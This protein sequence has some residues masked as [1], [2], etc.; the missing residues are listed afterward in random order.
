VLEELT[1][2]ERRVVELVVRGWTNQE[3]ADELC[4]TAKTIEWT[5]TKVYRK[6]RVR[7]RTELALKVGGFEPT[8][9]KV[10]L[11]L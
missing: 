7:S 1:E 8:T 9:Q 5:L 6:L 4:L 2:S 10:E 11:T 3:V